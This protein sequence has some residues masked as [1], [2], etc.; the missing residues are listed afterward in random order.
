[1]ALFLE[2]SLTPSDSWHRS[3]RRWNEQ[4]HA[5]IGGSDKSSISASTICTMGEVHLLFVSQQRL[6][7]RSAG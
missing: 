4:T 6:T 3:P 2:Y 5:D 7:I 1:M